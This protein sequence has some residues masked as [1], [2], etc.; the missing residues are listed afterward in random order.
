VILLFYSKEK[1][2][3]QV[4][5]V[6][7]QINNLS[8]DDFE[9]LYHIASEEL[10]DGLDLVE[11][12]ISS[13][14]KHPYSN[15]ILVDWNFFDT[16]IGEII[17]AVKAGSPASIYYAADVA[18]LVGCSVQYINKQA[19]DGIVVGEKKSKVW[20]FKENDVNDYLIK[21]GLPQINR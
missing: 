14:F 19:N 13:L 17:L 2:D 7:S 6:L 15:K 18:D 20:V 3:Q 4:N 9:E 8:K 16:P 5:E 12:I 21:K 10:D 1:Y 11:H